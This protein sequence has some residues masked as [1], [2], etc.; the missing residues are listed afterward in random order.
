MYPLCIMLSPRVVTHGMQFCWKWSRGILYS[1]SILYAAGNPSI[2]LRQMAWPCNISAAG[3]PFLT[4]L[5]FKLQLTSILLRSLITSTTSSSGRTELRYRLHNGVSR[6]VE[7]NWISASESL[8]T[9]PRVW[10][11]TRTEAQHTVWDFTRMVR[12]KLSRT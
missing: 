11:K 6:F 8:Y 5:F 9:I 1:W 2:E 4:A 7:G 12:S 3:S 10:D